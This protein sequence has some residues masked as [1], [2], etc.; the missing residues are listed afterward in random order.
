MLL[1]Q[2][3][4][5]RVDFRVVLVEPVAVLSLDW[6]DSLVCGIDERALQF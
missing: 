2:G 6:P 5:E 1:T 3:N 4:K